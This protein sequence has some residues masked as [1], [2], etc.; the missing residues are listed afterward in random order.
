MQGNRQLTTGNHP[1]SAQNFAV[2]ALLKKLH[3]AQPVRVEA[4][5]QDPATG[6]VG[7]VDVLPLLRQVDG[8]GQTHDPS[9]LY[10]QPFL[11]IQGGKNAVVVN[12]RPGDI[13]LSVFADRDCSVVSGTRQ[14]AQPG[15]PRF[16]DAGDGWYLGGF[17]NGA[18]ERFILVADDGIRIEGVASLDMHGERTVITAEAGCTINADVLING[19]LTWTGT[20]QGPAGPAQ[21]SGGVSNTGGEIA[22]NGIVLENHAHSGVTPGGGTSGGPV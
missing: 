4:V 16:M 13:G 11:R 22:S 1:H 12:P 8:E 7:Y 6:L 17:L 2:E 14:T 5:Y 21:F 15:S 10:R 3:T 9:P 19:N 20:A 18:A